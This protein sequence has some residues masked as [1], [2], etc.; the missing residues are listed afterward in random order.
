MK[1]ARKRKK[2]SMKKSN[3]TALRKCPKCAKDKD[4]DSVSKSE[5]KRAIA[6]AKKLSRRG[7]VLSRQE[8]KEIIQAATSNDDY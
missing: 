5:L 1:S 3:S 4:K 8:E 6:M 7:F 2:S